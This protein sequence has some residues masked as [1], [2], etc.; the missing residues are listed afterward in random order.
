[1]VEIFYEYGNFITILRVF[2]VS[3]EFVGK[4]GEWGDEV[5]D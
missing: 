5:R 4:V 1:M 3:W 2:L